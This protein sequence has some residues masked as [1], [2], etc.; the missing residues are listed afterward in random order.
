M[1]KAIQGSTRKITTT[2]IVGAATRKG[3][4]A[5][6]DAKAESSSSTAVLQ[7]SLEMLEQD[8]M[9]A[10]W[11]D[12]LKT[13]FKK[14][15]FIQ[16][17]QFLTTE[18]GSHTVYPPL[19]NVYSWSRFTPL[20]DVKVVILGQDPYHD[21]GQAHGLSFSVLPPTKAPPSLQ[22]IYKQ[23]AN[24]I[25]GFTKPSSGDLTPLARRGVL[26]LNTCL[27]VRAHKAGSHAKKGWEVFTTEVIRAVLRSKEGE[28]DHGVVFMAW[29][30][31]AQKTFDK[32][33]IDE[34]KHL[35]LRSAHPSPLSAQRGFL[36]NG[37]FR[38]A[39]DCIHMSSTKLH[40]SLPAPVVHAGFSIPQ[41]KSHVL[42]GVQD[43][44]W[45]DDEAEDAECPL[46]LEEMDISD[47]NFKPCICRFCWHHIKENLNKRCPACRRI[48]T[49]EAVEFKP[50]ATQDHK[51][52]TQQKKQRER[53]RKEV[54]ALGRRH[55]MNVRVVQRNVVY[56]VGIGPRFAKEELIPTLRSNEYFGQY[57]KITKI[58]LVKRTPSGGGAPIVGL[59]ITY[60]RKEDAARAI[61]AVD[62]AT[63]PGGG[64]EVMRA[65][66]GTT[67]YC[68]T[69]L[70]G[71]TCNDHSCMNLHEWGDEKDCFTK[72]D[73]TTLKHTM[74]AT[75]SRTRTTPSASKDDQETG[76]PRAASWAQKGTSTP[77]ASSSSPAARQST[78][79]GGA[80][81]R[82]P[83]PMR[84][85]PVSSHS[86]SSDSRPAVSRSHPERKVPSIKPSSQVSSRPATPASVPLSPT[87]ATTTENKEAASSK[88]EESAHGSEDSAAPAAPRHTGDPPS[89]SPAPRPPSTESMQ[90]SAPSIPLI[91]PGLPAVPPGLAAPAN[92]PPRVATASPQTPILSSQTSYQMSTAARALLDDVKARRESAL[93]ANVGISPFPDFDRTLRT[94]SGGEGGGFS[95]NLDPKLVEEGSDYDV[96]PSLEAEATIPFHGTFLDAF[97]A[98]KSSTSVHQPPPGLPYPHNPSRS[99]YDPHSIRTPNLGS[100]SMTT[101]NYIGSFNP[102]SDADEVSAPQPRQANEFMDDDTTRKVSRFGFARGRQGS[103]A[104]NS[105][106]LG[107]PPPTSGPDGHTVFAAPL[108]INSPSQSQWGS[109]DYNHSQPTSS[110]AS[111]HLHAPQGL[112][113][114][115]NRFQP[116]DASLSEAQLR[117]FIQTS[118]ERASLNQPPPNAP[119]PFKMMGQHFH[120]PA[121]MSASFGSPDSNLNALAYG[122]PPGLS[123]PT[124]RPL[125]QINGAG[126]VHDASRSTN[127]AAPPIPTSSSPV[128]SPD[129]FPA[130]PESTP[131]REKLATESPLSTSKILERAKAKAT[132]KAIP[133]EKA[134]EVK[135]KVPEQGRKNREKDQKSDA[136]SVPAEEPLISTN[137]SAA[138]QAAQAVTQSEPTE[139]VMTRNAPKDIK[140]GGHKSSTPQKSYRQTP[141]KPSPASLTFPH[142]APQDPILS[143]K[144]KKNKPSAVK[145]VK[146]HKED[147]TLDDVST[148]GS[149]A[150]ETPVSSVVDPATRAADQPQFCAPT[151]I[152]DLMQEV[153]TRHPELDLASHPFFDLHKINPTS[154]MP[155]EYGPLVHALSA[156]SVGGG[157][158]ANHIP[159][160]SIDNAV[161][162]F[163]QLLE[164]L[165]QTISDLLRLLPR[166]TWDDS[167]SFDGVLRDMLKGDD[168][169]D[170]GNEEGHTKEDEVAALTLALERRARW[171]EVQLS[172][173]EELHRD[174]NTAAVRAVLAFNDN[175]WDK[176]HF[177]PHSGSTLTKFDH[178][179]MVD[180][181]GGKYRA[182]NVDELEKKLVVAKEAVTFAEAELREIMEKMQSIKPNSFY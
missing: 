113:Q 88:K 32:I 36:G 157:A 17:K 94:L 131:K 178:L 55:F 69:F 47:L 20:G 153:A 114:Q 143:K 169:P 109:Q 61:A 46:C 91:P 59:Y 130:L 161:S 148:N 82:P 133:A 9:G 57:G 105:S 6:I 125:T 27:T 155:L 35:L 16:L 50:I 174:I 123:F 128:L 56:V 38:K 65:S 53:E 135:V 81:S 68:M 132:K 87:T 40:P 49:D 60:Y 154:K 111:P 168:F 122:P 1:P 99:I 2:Q 139:K 166:T 22:N 80:P 141:L 140:A 8:T 75:E 96:L 79:R 120:D 98:L 116:Y 112:Y 71:V 92:R 97:P 85:T 101:T 176:H 83:Q 74:K 152:N 165:T 145:P 78:R 160:G 170:D 104:T 7:A 62:G 41:S 33:G 172:K 84:T 118:R 86:H 108:G 137:S 150:V 23:L 51:R 182:M 31:P 44:Y 73:L 95:F 24:D 39:N 10:S 136:H 72:E 138:L 3:K 43:A 28:S 14:P 29:G 76:L 162:S 4:A 13:E 102:F 90:S 115:P 34:K 171:M 58:V 52:L 30:L 119:T 167:A 103:T 77:T 54:E 175:G 93:S 67:K 110:A 159:S 63:S 48:Y 45:S 64:R 121:I 89:D 25:P 107:T 5:V 129:D 163:Q 151:S 181:G 142:P 149:A 180:I 134:T 158:F 146:V 11:R 173:L 179:G 21:V 177:L 19:E 164:T 42:A 15:Y 127:I 18:L 126:N 156:L 117:E 147:Q 144:P 70:R 124:Q 66:Y 26:W 37:H 106:H 100:T 12:A